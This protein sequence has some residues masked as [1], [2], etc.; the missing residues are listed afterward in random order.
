MPI[1]HSH[2]CILCP[3]CV[4]NI[5]YRLVYKSPPENRGRIC[6]KTVDLCKSRRW[7]LRTLQDEGQHN[8]RRRRRRR[9]RQ[10]SGMSDRKLRILVA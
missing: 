10:S 6:S 9:Q 4:Y 1:H 3:K 8:A 2:L 5:P 7:F